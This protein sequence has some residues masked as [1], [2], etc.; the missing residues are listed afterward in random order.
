[1]TATPFLTIVLFLAIGLLTYTSQMLPMDASGAETSSPTTTNFTNYD[2]SK[3]GFQVQYPANWNITEEQTAVWFVSPVDSTGNIR[4]ERQPASN[5]SLSDLVNVQLLQSKESYKDLKVLSSNFTS[6]DGN[7]ANRT[8]YQFR[9][10]EPKFM[11]VDVFDF[12]A[13][14]ISTIKNNNFYTFLYYS[15]PENFHI[16]LPIAQKMISTFILE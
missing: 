7:P 1:M 10:E 5:L 12:T 3:L 11:G 4:I 2:G 15:N 14:Q 9:I 8:D 16:F 6:L 13:I